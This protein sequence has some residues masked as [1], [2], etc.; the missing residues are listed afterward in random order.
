M[1]QINMATRDELADVL[2]RR[3]ATS[4]RIERGGIPDDFTSG[5]GL[6]RKHAM[7]LRRAEQAGRRSGPRPGR[8]LYD[9]AVREALIVIWE[10]SDRVRGKRKRA[11]WDENY[12]LTLL[13]LF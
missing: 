10:A 6:H 1:R 2:A 9:A 3:Y 11:S 7:R 12:L 5:S 4:D 13:A 8:R